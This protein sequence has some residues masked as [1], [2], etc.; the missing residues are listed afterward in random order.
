[1]AGQVVKFA[2]KVDYF[3]VIADP[4]QQAIPSTWP[5]F[6]RGNNTRCQ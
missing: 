2:D 6:G 4:D 1:M 5:V 3:D